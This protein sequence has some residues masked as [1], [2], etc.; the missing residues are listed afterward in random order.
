MTPRTVWWLYLYLAYLFCVAS[1]TMSVEGFYA[2]ANNLKA[3]QYGP[4][5]LETAL[6]KFLDLLGAKKAL[7]VT[8]RSLFEK[9]RPLSLLLRVIL[10]FLDRPT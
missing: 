5:C 10:I 2:W 3:I 6:P 7:I 9:V 1:T 8:G 4:G